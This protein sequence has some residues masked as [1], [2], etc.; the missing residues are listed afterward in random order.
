MCVDVYAHI[1]ANRVAL[2]H[3]APRFSEIPLK[4]GE[5]KKFHRHQDFTDMTHAN[6]TVFLR[7]VF[8]K[9]IQMFF[10]A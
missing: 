10:F 8:L 2:A 6:P 4:V 5:Q 1:C 3:L 9:K 7:S